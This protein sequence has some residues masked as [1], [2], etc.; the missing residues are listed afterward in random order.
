MTSDAVTSEQQVQPPA[1]FPLL[2]DPMNYVA[3]AWDLSKTDDRRAYWLKLFRDHFAGMLELAMVDAQDRGVAHDRAEEQI[4]N[5]RAGFG[6]FLKQVEAEPDVFGPLTILLMCE[7]RERCLR[8]ADIPDPYRLAKQQ[9]NESALAVLPTVFTEIDA[10]SGVEQIERVMR[11]IF[12]GNIFDL[13]AVKTIEMFKDGKVDFHDTLNKLKHRP[14]FVDHL[15]AWRDRWLD[16]PAHKC[17][18]MFVDN[19]GPDVL[20]GMIPFAREL[21]RRGTGVILTANETPSLNDITHTELVIL[22]DRVAKLDPLISKSL[23]SG[24]LELI[25]SG[26]GAPLID[27]RRINSRLAE[28]VYRRDVDLCVIEG[29][30]RAIETNFDAAFDC[31]TLKL[32]MIKDLG[33]GEAMGAELYD[34]VLRFDAAE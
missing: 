33:V 12:A 32:A 20:L 14:W 5:A 25:S 2:A 16:G 6:A 30:G 8:R 18:V 34:L 29:M 24:E 17:A 9:E 3:C 13:G 23:K 22:I 31:D 4:E 27:L 28:A 1:A 11:G 21:L 26:N 19:A 7:A 15:D 10:L